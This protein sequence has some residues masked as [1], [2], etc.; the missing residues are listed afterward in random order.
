MTSA[1][2]PLDTQSVLASIREIGHWRVRI[3]P[4]SAKQ[5][6]DSSLACRDGVEDSAVLLRGW[7]YPHVPRDLNGTQTSSAVPG[8]WEAIV[9]WRGHREVWRLMQ[10]GQFIHYRALSEDLSPAFRTERVLDVWSAVFTLLEV[11]EFARRLGRAGQYG[12]RL[13]IQVDLVNTKGRRLAHLDP[14][15]M[16]GRDYVAAANCT[17]L[18]STLGI[19][20][21]DSGAR[22]VA[23]DF[24][25]KIFETFGYAIP[26]RVITEIQSELLERR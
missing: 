19:P 8:G 1:V 15:R 6:F 24:A 17:E 14:K 26:S 7:D 22:S 20:T 21:T 5:R 9:D 2:A 25:T 10:S 3:I 16:L 12:T 13:D 4:E 18:R 23:H 11:L